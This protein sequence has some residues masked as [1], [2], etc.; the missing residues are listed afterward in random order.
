GFTQDALATALAQRS[1]PVASLIDDWSDWIV[2][3]EQGHIPTVAHR[4][5]VTVALALHVPV[6][7]L[8]PPPV[9]DGPLPTVREQLQAK[10]LLQEEI[11]ALGHYVDLDDRSACIICTAEDL[12]P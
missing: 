12:T 10:G 7:A 6:S 8:L 1:G 3:V 11:Q 9:F 4:I 2:A 5:V